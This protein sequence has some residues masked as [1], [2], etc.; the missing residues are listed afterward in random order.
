[1]L[2]KIT[3]LLHLSGTNCDD[4]AWLTSI[5]LPQAL[6]RAQSS[7][8]FGS[9]LI[10]LLL[11]WICYTKKQKSLRLFPTSLISL[12]E[13]YLWKKHCANCHSFQLLRV[14]LCYSR[15][16]METR[17]S[18]HGISDIMHNFSLQV[19]GEWPWHPCREPWICLPTKRLCNMEHMEIEKTTLI[20]KGTISFGNIVV[21]LNSILFILSS[22]LS[23]GG[24]QK[25]G[26]P[27]KSGSFP[28]ICLA[29]VDSL[30]EGLQGDVLLQRFLYD[31]KGCCEIGKE[32]FQLRK[33]LVS[34]LS[35]PEQETFWLSLW[36]WCLQTTRLLVQ[37]SAVKM[38]TKGAFYSAD[39][40]HLCLRKAANSGS[41]QQLAVLANDIFF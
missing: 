18:L 24:C 10:A 28:K 34:C 36:S 21:P 39:G 38:C 7:G 35:S 11:L 2:G 15:V 27:S 22:L 9:F 3:L 19:A 13:G 41:G 23:H 16:H 30:C 20:G 37:T 25:P 32:C 14:S 40:G 31:W 5:P 26:P 6:V 4:I 12:R 8:A 33:V 17:P 29:W 1:M